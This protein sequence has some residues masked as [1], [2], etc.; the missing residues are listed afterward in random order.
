MTEDRSRDPTSN[1]PIADRFF[2]PP[3]LTATTA[4]KTGLVR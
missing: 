3:E 2:I 1:L 4:L